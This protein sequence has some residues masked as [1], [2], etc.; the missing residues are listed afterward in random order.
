MYPKY[1]DANKLHLHVRLN[2]FC[3]E[4]FLWSHFNLFANKYHGSRDHGVINVWRSVQTGDYRLMLTNKRSSTVKLVSGQLSPD[5]CPTVS[6]FG[7][8][9]IFEVDQ[10][11]ANCGFTLNHSPKQKKM[12]ADLKHNR[13]IIWLLY[14]FSPPTKK[15]SHEIG[16]LSPDKPNRLS[17]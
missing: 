9:N 5:D 6:W 14:F 1:L 4:I 12:P 17:L 15:T 2:I 3:K 16:R 13:V 7:V 8:A 10:Q 11:P